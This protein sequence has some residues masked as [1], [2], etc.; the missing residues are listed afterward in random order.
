M[1]DTTH[2][3]EQLNKDIEEYL[4]KGGKITVV[5]SQTFARGYEDAVISRLTIKVKHE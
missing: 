2:I 5:P 3:R 4:A 1:K